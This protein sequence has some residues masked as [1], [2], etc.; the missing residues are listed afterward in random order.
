MDLQSNGR[1]DGWT[2]ERTDRQ[3]EEAKKV[4][5]YSHWFLHG[6]TK[7]RTDGQM[8]RQ[9]DRQADKQKD[10]RTEGHKDLGTGEKESVFTWTDR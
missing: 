4:K 7:C 10:R 3:M 5:I 8:D 1:T 9:M 2:V 6:W